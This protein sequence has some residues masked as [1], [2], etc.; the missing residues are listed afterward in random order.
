[1]QSRGNKM[2]KTEEKIVADVTKIEAIVTEPKLSAEEEALIN[3]AVMDSNNTEKAR[4]DTLLMNVKDLESHIK[5]LKDRILE[6]DTE[7]RSRRKLVDGING[8]IAGAQ[9]ELSNVRARVIKENEA[10]INEINKKKNELDATDKTLQAL[11][12]KNEALLISNQQKESSLIEDRRNCFLQVA[13]MKK[14]LADNQSE[15][16]KR[17]ADI[18]RRE[19]ELAED[20]SK[21]ESERASLI[22][23]MN[24][25]SAI[26]NENILLAQEVERQRLNNANILMG[27]ESERQLFEEQKLVQAHR[28]KI[29]SDKFANEEKRLREWEQ[30]LKD[31]DLETRAK[32]AKA[33]KMIR[34]FQLEKEASST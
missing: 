26:K 5:F 11:V 25:I 31:F 1:M 33:D 23:E 16:G 10:L 2:L 29:Q 21:F 13:D 18:L 4:K 7:F 6:L 8:G 30:N 27:I 32:S 19:Q 28:D 24:K 34:Q 20:R 9:A 22:P 12:A 17:E 15:W 14:A 3:K